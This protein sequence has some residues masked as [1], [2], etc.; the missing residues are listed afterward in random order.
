MIHVNIG[1]NYEQVGKHLQLICL[2]FNQCFDMFMLFIICINYLQLYHHNLQSY[3][4]GKLQY[5]TNLNSSA[6][7]G[8]D[9]PINKPSSM[10]FGRNEVVIFYPDEW[11]IEWDM[12]YG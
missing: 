11:D 6:I 8:D 10:G 3:Y 9:S 4:L 5:F 1:M 12:N 7:K 2:Q